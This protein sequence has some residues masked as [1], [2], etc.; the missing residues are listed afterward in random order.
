MYSS[1]SLESAIFFQQFLTIKSWRKSIII[2]LLAYYHHILIHFHTF[3]YLNVNYIYIYIQKILQRFFNLNFDY[4]S[5]NARN[6]ILHAWLTWY[7]NLWN[8]SYKNIHHID[9]LTSFI[10]YNSFLMADRLFVGFEPISSIAKQP[11]V[12]D[13]VI[14]EVGIIHVLVFFCA[15]STL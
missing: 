7:R 8:I 1:I 3:S 4:F 5:W 11:F 6:T 9:G 15:F 13:I 14:K 10:V 12:I 2:I